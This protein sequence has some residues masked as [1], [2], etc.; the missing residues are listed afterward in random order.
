MLIKW[1]DTQEGSLMQVCAKERNVLW[2]TEV[3]THIYAL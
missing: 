2:Y 3:G 1:D